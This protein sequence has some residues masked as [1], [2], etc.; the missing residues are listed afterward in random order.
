M[1]IARSSAHVHG[2]NVSTVGSVNCS[3]NAHTGIAFTHVGASN[4]ARTTMNTPVS[5]NCFMAFLLSADLPHYPSSYLLISEPFLHSS[6][7]VLLVIK[8][9]QKEC[10]PV[11][12]IG[13]ISH[14]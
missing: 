8:Y 10:R 12:R 14:R 6:V 1:V 3:V 5:V 9:K 7:R 2:P 11:A 13:A 4:K